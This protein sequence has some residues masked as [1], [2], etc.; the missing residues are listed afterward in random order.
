MTETLP[1]VGVE[2]FDV[3]RLRLREVAAPHLSPEDELARDRVWDAAVQ[4]NPSLFDGP[5]VACAGLGWEGPRSLVLSWARVTYRHYALRRIPGA[6]CWMPSLFVSIVQPADD[7]R[8][9]VARMSPSTAAPGRWQLPG[10]SVEP[11]E[12]HEVLDEAA[13]RRHAARELTEE[14]GLDT[15]PEELTR[16]AVT[17]GEHR[18]VGLV[19][20]AP[21]RRPSVLEERFAALV[22]AE[23]AAGRVPELDRIAVV[24]STAELA[25]LDGPHADYLEPVVRRYTEPLR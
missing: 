13:L 14:T 2:L 8:V 1:P 16:W 15:T 9:L 10:G 6:T 23:Q 22:A 25:G 4:V 11:P 17:R 12:A 5:V 21:L 19:F 3:H 18:S 24:G 20:L 7:G